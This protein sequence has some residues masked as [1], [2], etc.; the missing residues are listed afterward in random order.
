RAARRSHVERTVGTEMLTIFSTLKPFKGHIG[1]IQ[2]NAIASWALLHP[3]PEIILFGNEEGTAEAAMDIGALHVSQV[4]RNEFGTPL[5]NDLFQKA[6][7]LAS[8]QT[9]CYVNADIL[10][11]DDFSE[12]VIGASRIRFERSEE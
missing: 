2:R 6:E 9:L 5:L 1:I 8:H 12:A 4:A 11:L 7:Q 10:L 3:R